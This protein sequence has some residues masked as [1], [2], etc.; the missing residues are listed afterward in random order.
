MSNAEVIR[1]LGQKDENGDYSITWI[2]AEQRFVNALRNSSNNNLEEQYLLGVDSYTE[3]AEDSKG[4]QTIK[5]YFCKLDSEEDTPTEK[6]NYY[7]LET[8]K[9][10][11]P[12]ADYFFE[13]TAVKMPNRPTEVAFESES[14]Y[15]SILKCKSP[16]TFKYNN[17]VLKIETLSTIQEDNLYFVGKGS[18]RFENKTFIAN[19]VTRLELIDNN[20]KVI[21]EIITKSLNS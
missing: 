12:E 21:R 19:K 14:A 20:H 9:T 2:G 7:Y 3:I 11:E 15:E 1:Y 4:N 8:R 16:T 13:G 6:E 5:K 18:H 17:G 10:E